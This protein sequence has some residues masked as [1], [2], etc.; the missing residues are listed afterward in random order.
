M[1]DTTDQY[2]I[3]SWKENY[4]GTNIADYI[5]QKAAEELGDI[6]LKVPNAKDFL[7]TQTTDIDTYNAQKKALAN[8]INMI[9][10]KYGEKDIPQAAMTQED[11]DRIN[12]LKSRTK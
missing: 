8:Y 9:R 7:N 11:Y 5:G 4:P 1:A 2:E 6:Q 3:W 10:K 12:A